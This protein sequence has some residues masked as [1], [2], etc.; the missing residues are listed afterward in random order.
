MSLHLFTAC[1][2]EASATASIMSRLSVLLQQMYVSMVACLCGA[3][4]WTQGTAQL[5][6]TSSTALYVCYIAILYCC[7]EG[8]RSEARFA[9]CVANF[10]V[11]IFLSVSPSHCILFTVLLAIIFHHSI[12]FESLLFPHHYHILFATT[13]YP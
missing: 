4:E 10:E 7:I 11:D 12:A 8:I 9:C 13:L 2:Q 5:C 1:R 3:E 6:V